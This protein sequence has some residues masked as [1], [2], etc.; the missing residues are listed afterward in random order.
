MARCVFRLVRRSVVLAASSVEGERCEDVV[1]H[2]A[3]AS[4]S[5]S[6]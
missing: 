4:F 5:G 2:C 3:M 1:S 6:V